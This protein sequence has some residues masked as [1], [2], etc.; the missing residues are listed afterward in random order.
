MRTITINNKTFELNKT[1]DCNRQF[2]GHGADR[3]A[4]YNVYNRP[5][6]RKASI[7]VWWCNWLDEIIR[8]GGDGHLHISGHNCNFFTISG[9]VANDETGSECVPVY[10]TYAHQ[11]AYM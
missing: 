8:N 4:I 11:R 10:I 5:S 9:W 2:I 6:V 3:N 1:T 7:W